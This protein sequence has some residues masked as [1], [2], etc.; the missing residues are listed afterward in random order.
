MAVASGVRFMN[1]I[2]TAKRLAVCNRPSTVP[3]TTDPL[4]IQRALLRA[5][6]SRSP[7]RAPPTMTP[8]ETWMPVNTR[9]KMLAMVQPGRHAR[10][11]LRAA[12]AVVQGG[13]DRLRYHPGRLG[14][15]HEPGLAQDLPE[16]LPACLEDPEQGYVKSRL[17]RPGIDHE[18]DDLER[19]ARRWW[20]APLPG[21][22]AAARPGCRR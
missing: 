17:A 16:Q 10:H 14:Q 20:R 8:V 21:S 19:R 2:G 9:K 12:A 6:S 13:G 18:R 7:P 22:P 15:E 1:T 11:D 4:I 5:S 3:A